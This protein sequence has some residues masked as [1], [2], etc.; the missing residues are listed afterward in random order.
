MGNYVQCLCCVRYHLGTIAFGSLLIAIVQ[1]IRVF[2]EYLD[3]KLKGSENPAA[4][5]FIK[6]VLV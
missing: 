3:A 1:L 2:L 4:K 6:Y 5:F